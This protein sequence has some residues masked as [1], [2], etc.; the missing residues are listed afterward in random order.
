MGTPTDRILISTHDVCLLHDPGLYHPERASRLTAVRQGIEISGVEDAIEFVDAPIAPTEALTLIHPSSLLD[1]LEEM[2]LTGG[3]AI[4]ADTGVSAG[5]AEAA[6]RAAGAGLDLID[7]LDR[8]EGS[9]GWAVVR[10][11]G[12]HATATRQMGFCLVNNVAVAARALASRGER[13]AVVDVD[14]HHGNGTQD[15]FYRDGNV[16]FISFHQWPWY[17]YS[18]QAGEIGEDDGRYATVNIPV[19]AGATGDV[20]R[21]GIEQVVAPV[22]EAFAPTWMLI[23]L[24]FDGHRDDPLTELGL[25][26]G[27]FGDIVF[28]LLQFV[29]AGRRL[30]FLEGGY[31]LRALKNST[32]AVLSA[33]VGERDRPPEQS[34]SGGPGDG[35]IDEARRIHVE[36]QLDG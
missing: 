23:S 12:H 20:Y 30:M 22:L 31:D 5:S 19:P 9:V 29:P 3:G 26:S 34:T 17:P 15:I 36:H 1:R 24:G 33:V 13:V 28:D 35:A 8:G 11:P 4:D 25:T 7:R 27:D 16:L 18:G 21:T 2:S 32:A 14:A 10:P 6:R